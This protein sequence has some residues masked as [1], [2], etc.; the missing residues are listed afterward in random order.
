MPCSL[1]RAEKFCR[2]CH[3]YDKDTSGVCLGAMDIKYLAIIARDQATAEVMGAL[4]GWYEG[5][6]TGPEEPQL[7]KL[8]KDCDYKEPKVA[9]SLAKKAEEKKK[10]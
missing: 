4:E 8:C 5:V 9:D 10:K 2:L 7:L 3:A 6:R 1:A